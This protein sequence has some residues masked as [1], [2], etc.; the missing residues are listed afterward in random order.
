MSGFS[1][2]KKLS[3]GWLFPYRSKSWHFF[4]N[5]KSLCGKYIINEYQEG[6]LLPQLN[7]EDRKCKKCL[8]KI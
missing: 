5:K 4:E 1:L 2:L 3:K 7:L 6:G 8:V